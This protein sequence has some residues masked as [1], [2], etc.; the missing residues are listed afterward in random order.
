MPMFIA[1]HKWKPEEQLTILKELYDFFTKFRPRA[2]EDVQCCSTYMSD[3]ETFCVWIAP[4]A[5]TLEKGFEGHS[6]T[7]KKGTEVVPVV[8]AI[9]PTMDYLLTLWKNILDLA[10]S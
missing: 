6:P 8:Q 4:S 10:P 9:P 1:V 7:L 3:N 5:E 2:R